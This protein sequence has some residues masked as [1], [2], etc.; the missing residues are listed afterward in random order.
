MNEDVLFPKLP[1]D[2]IECLLPYG[3]EVRLEPGDTLFREGEPESEFF[4]I[5]EGEVRITKAVAGA[6]TTLRVH[7]AGEFTGALSIFQG[8]DSIATG[9]AV[10]PCRLLRVDREGFG[11]LLTACPEIAVTMLL[12]MAER[13]PEAETMTRQ[14]EKLAALGK[15]SAGLAHELNNPA[16][17]ARRAAA[18]LRETLRRLNPLTLKLGELCLTP[19]VRAWLTGF[20]EEMMARG[21]S[22]ASDDVL[23]CSDAEDAVGDWLDVRGIPD[24]WELAPALVGAGLDPGGLDALAG[25]VGDAALP[26]TLAW[27]A[28]AAAADD[29]ARQV[30]GSAGRI[31]ELVGA[32]KS[33]S[34]MDRAPTQDVDVHEGLDSTLTILGHKLKAIKVVKNYDRTLPRLAAFGGELNQVWTNL[35]DNAADALDGQGRGTLTVRTA[36]EGKYALVEIADDG[37]GIPEDIQARVFE[38]FF[39]TKGVGKGTGL[40]LDISYRIVV[41][42][43]HGELCVESR[44]GDTRFQAR[45]PLNVEAS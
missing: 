13:R 38:P 22:A 10:S 9:R 15:L 32:I 43:H 39:T 36:R 12:A 26:D 3:Q 5:R 1:P 27:L 11:A 30:E 24:G 28:A 2:Q 16:A 23:A 34:Y 29:L 40:G 14:R 42:R 20:A 6:E 37:P 45:L 17:A 41:D 19:D 31:S 44:P 25:R 8:T 35:I 18:D 7:G 4:V 33:Y 21:Q